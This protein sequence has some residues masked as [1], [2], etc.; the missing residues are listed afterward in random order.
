MNQFPQPLDATSTTGDSWGLV[1][2]YVTSDGVPKVVLMIR[3]DAASSYAAT[4][5]GHPAIAVFLAE[6]ADGTGNG[7]WE[8]GHLLC[9]QWDKAKEMAAQQLKETASPK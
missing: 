6:D 5:D 3:T 4:L 8:F 1:S 7:P 9:Q 2:P